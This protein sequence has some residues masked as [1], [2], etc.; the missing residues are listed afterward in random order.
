MADRLDGWATGR[1]GDWLLTCVEHYDFQKLSKTV[2][3]EEDD[4]EKKDCSYEE[5]S[6]EGKDGGQSITKIDNSIHSQY[7]NEP[8]VNKYEEK[9]KSFMGA[10][11][12]DQSGM[13]GAK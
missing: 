1:M 9:R 7:W 13:K 6:A 12:Y 8:Y 11:G 2:F 4:M 10:K 3:E 5:M